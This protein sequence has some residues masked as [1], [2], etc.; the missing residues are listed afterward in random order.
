MCDFLTGTLQGA[1]Y[2]S[3]DF[4]GGVKEV[5]VARH[6]N[7][8]LKGYNAS[9]V[10][11]ISTTENVDLFKIEFDE[12]ASFTQ[13]TINAENGSSY[14]QQNFTGQIIG[15]S[16]YDDKASFDGYSTSGIGNL[17][18]NKCI[19]FIITHSGAQAT[20]GLENG[21]DVTLDSST[22]TNM[23]DFIGFTMNAVGKERMLAHAGSF[24]NSSNFTKYD[25]VQ[26]ASETTNGIDDTPSTEETSSDDIM[27]VL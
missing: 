27:N 16:P 10:A 11:Q 5:F 4:Q 25:G 19:I 13:E 2:C 22:G 6:S 26:T 15:F 18:Y 23:E 24:G 7:A 8:I 21:L 14:V 17:P 3:G 9:G 12:N 1:S 20:L